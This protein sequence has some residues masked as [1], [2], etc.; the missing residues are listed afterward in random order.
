MFALSTLRRNEYTNIRRSKPIR[1]YIEKADSKYSTILKLGNEN[2]Q[3]WNVK[4]THVV[5]DYTGSVSLLVSQVH[6]FLLDTPRFWLGPRDNSSVNTGR[7]S[8]LKAAYTRRRFEDEF[9][10]NINDGA[11]QPTRKITSFVPYGQLLYFYFTCT[12]KCRGRTRNFGF[13]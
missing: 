10:N 8:R 12:D 13:R 2:I 7:R 11:V 4:F 6:V 3:N 1:I 9:L 5:G